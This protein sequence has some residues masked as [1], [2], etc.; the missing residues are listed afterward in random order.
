[1]R[2]APGG[3]LVPAGCAGVSEG[4]DGLG[5][6]SREAI[7]ALVQSAYEPGPLLSAAGSALRRNGQT[8][9]G[10]LKGDVGQGAGGVVIRQ[11][12]GCTTDVGGATN[13][14]SRPPRPQRRDPPLVAAGV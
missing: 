8:G 5:C 11:Q 2:R 14:T 4:R 13:T 3:I 10:L 7:E 1:M 6:A 12:V 9:V